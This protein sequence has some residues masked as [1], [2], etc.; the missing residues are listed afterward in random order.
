MTLM[1][2]FPELKKRVNIGGGINC[3]TI[4]VHKMKGIF[5]NCNGFKDTNKHGFISDLCREQ[6]LSFIVVSETGWKG[7]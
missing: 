4:R 2:Y 1:L 3:F 6:S 7:F 5:W